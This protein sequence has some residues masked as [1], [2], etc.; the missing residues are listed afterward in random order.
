[1]EKNLD[2]KKEYKSDDSLRKIKK[3]VHEK[4]L[5][6]FPLSIFIAFV[7][8]GDDLGEVDYNQGIAIRFISLK[9]GSFRDGP[10]VLC[11]LR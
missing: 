3:K 1:M 11:S 8:L 4:F 10:L 9:L 7:P 6:K 2:E 5:G